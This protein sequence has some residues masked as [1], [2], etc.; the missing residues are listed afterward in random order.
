VAGLT[1]IQEEL[2]LLMEVLEAEH[3]GVNLRELE[4]L[5]KVILVEELLEA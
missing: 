5:D 2:M 1:E 3:R 4:Q